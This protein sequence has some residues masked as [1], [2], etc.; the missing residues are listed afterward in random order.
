MKILKDE[1]I[2]K[3]NALIKKINEMNTYFKN[4]NPE[5]LSGNNKR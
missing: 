1:N 4:F 3:L 2:I 5:Y